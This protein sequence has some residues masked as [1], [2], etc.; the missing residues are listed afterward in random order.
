MGLTP[1]D[2]LLSGFRQPGGYTLKEPALHVL[3]P[4]PHSKGLVWD[5]TT[6]DEFVRSNVGLLF[7]TDSAQD[8]TSGGNQV[9]ARLFDTAGQSYPATLHRAGL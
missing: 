4:Y 5:K 3:A 7:Q 6:P 1:R 2:S 9:D 8:S